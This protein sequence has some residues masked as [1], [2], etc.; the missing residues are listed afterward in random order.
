MLMPVWVMGAI[1]YHHMPAF[2]RRAALIMFMATTGITIAACALDVSE[3]WRAWLYR[4]APPFWRAHYSSQFLYD[5]VLGVV[6]AANFAA[7][8]SL[9]ASLGKLRAI[10]RPIRYLASFTLSLYVFHAPLTELLVHVLHVDHALPFYGTLAVCVFA[11]AQ[12]TEKRT[13]WYRRQISRVW[14]PRK[15]ELRAS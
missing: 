10:E 1:L 3:L 13:G 15:T 5:I 8:A 9:S 4:I 2:S 6:V 12:L 14:T 11:L 7:T